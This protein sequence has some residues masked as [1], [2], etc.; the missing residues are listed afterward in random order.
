MVKYEF[1]TKGRAV[2]TTAALLSAL[3]AQAQPPIVVDW[4]QDEL[5]WDDWE[6]GVRTSGSGSTTMYVGGAFGQEFSGCGTHVVGLTFMATGESQYPMVPSCIEIAGISQQFCTWQQGVLVCN[7]SNGSF[8]QI[9]VLGIYSTGF[10]GEGVSM[11]SGPGT[12]SIGDASRHA[13]LVSGGNFFLGGTSVISSNY[14]LDCADRIWKTHSPVV[15]EGTSWTTCL[16]DHFVGFEIWNDTLLAIGFPR[17]T[18]VDTS[19]GTQA[20]TFDLYAGVNVNNGHSAISGDTLYWASRLADGQLHIGRFLI[21]TGPVWEVTLPFSSAPLELFA[22]G[23]G[24][25]WTATGNSI[26]W[27]DRSDGSYQNY[28]IGTTVKGIDIVGNTVAI[29]GSMDGS[30]SYVLHGH[31][32]P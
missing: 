20:G 14:E 8:T 24:R 7:Y 16:M 15:D 23:M 3:M 27:V 6:H 17:V 32:I 30:T 12:N 19:D 13:L 5:L 29:T 18:K 25:L 4:I 26:I 2:V 22:D 1:T 11:Y 31:V 28:A 21:G 10:P 9:Q